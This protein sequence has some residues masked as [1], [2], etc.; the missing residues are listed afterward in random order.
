MK[1]L[2]AVLL[3]IPVLLCS[4]FIFKRKAKPI[5]ILSSNI[6]TKDTAQVIENTFAA[7]QRIY[8]AL[9]APDGFKKPGV[10]LQISKQADNVSNWGFSIISSRD[11]YLNTSEKVYRS[12]IYLRDGGHYILQ[13]FYLDNKDYPFAHREFRVK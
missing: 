4:G 10:R 1:K 2:A 9:Y 8:F 6:I 12:H 3:I 7:G 5:I 13:F 11:I